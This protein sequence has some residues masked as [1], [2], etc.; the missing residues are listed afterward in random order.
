MDHQIRG[1][2]IKRI[3]SNNWY[4]DTATGNVVEV[5]FQ[6]QLSVLAN[7][8]ANCLSLLLRDTNFKQKDLVWQSLGG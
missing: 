8:C 7:F 3:S 2:A 4:K 5:E 1:F 6:V